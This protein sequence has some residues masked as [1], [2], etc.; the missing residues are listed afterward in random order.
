VSDVFT[1]QYSQI[2]L[3]PAALHSLAPVS[4]VP[5]PPGAQ[6]TQLVVAAVHRHM[7]DGEAIM[8]LRRGKRHFARVTFTENAEG[9]A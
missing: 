7:N 8:V 1:C 5:L 9:G 4:D 2:L 6:T 3:D